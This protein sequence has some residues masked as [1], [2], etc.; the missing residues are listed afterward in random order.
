MHRIVSLRHQ[1]EEAIRQH[2]W[3]SEPAG[4][5]DPIAYTMQ[6][7]GKRMR[8]VLLLLGNEMCGGNPYEAMPAALGIE[9][10]HNF[11]LLHDDI[12]DQAPL[13]RGKETVYRKYSLNAAILSGDVMFA[14]AC[15]LVS[16][17]PDSV[18]RPVLNRFHR[19]AIEV[20]EGQQRDLEFEKSD[21]VSI[22]AYLKMIAQK[23]AVLLGCSLEI[24]CLIARGGPELAN[25]FYK[26]GFH[27]GI[28]FQLQ[29]DILDAYAS[30]ERFGKQVGGDIV[31]NKK[32]YLLLKA[33][34]IASESERDS[35]N[36]W[37][38]EVN[39]DVAEKVAG[40]KQI[41]DALD[42]YRLAC[43]ERDNHFDRA[44]D[45]LSL[46]P[47]ADERKEPLREL[48]A[49]LLNRDH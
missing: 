15:R 35:L 42:I 32:T 9:L 27:L 26:I 36:H 44:M 22:E 28:S 40:V 11:T 47:I 23:T 21:A 18:L 14:E 1:V 45:E 25:H 29:D 3:G 31:Q 4:L 37:M 10:F 39:H 17:V 33:F 49:A 16:Q 13:R 34:E 8:P 41:Y 7:S 24:G 43:E 30:A 46:L 38:S 12:M 48:A 20:C 2:N 19:S 6:V 5:Y